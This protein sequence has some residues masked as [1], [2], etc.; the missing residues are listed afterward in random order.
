MISFTE[1]AAKEIHRAMSAQ[2]LS[3]EVAVRVGVKA[4]GCSGF[5]YT[6]DFD[7]KR[8]R[9]DLEFESHGLCLL[10]DKKSHLYID[11]TEIDWS[12]DLMD[13]GLKFNNPAA[14]SSCGCKTS[15]L[16]EPPEQEEGF[17]PS[18]M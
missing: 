5:T 10:V 11:G 16:F 3:D 7:S 15:F 6:L 1:N 9:F 8:T 2:S 17:K 13:R 12:Y 14:K 18:W 4:G